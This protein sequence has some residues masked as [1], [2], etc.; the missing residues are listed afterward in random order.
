M[1]HSSWFLVGSKTSKLNS[2]PNQWRISQLLAA[3]TNPY[4]S[5]ILLKFQQTTLSVKEWTGRCL[6]STENEVAL[7]KEDV[8]SFQKSN[9][10]S[11]MLLTTRS[12]CKILFP[13][14]Y[15][16][17]LTLWFRLNDQMRVN[18]FVPECLTNS[19]LS[20]IELGCWLR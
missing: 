1:S 6:S 9:V 5:V 3:A 4:S 18:C 2:A 17:K 14:P 20:L 10:S 12:E 15:R 8:G 19:K 16:A 11:L 7:R 13:I